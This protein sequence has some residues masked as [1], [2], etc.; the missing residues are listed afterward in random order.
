MR[1][2]VVG[3]SRF[4]MRNDGK[5]GTI[6]DLY[7]NPEKLNDYIHEGRQAVIDKY[8]WAVDGAKLTELYHS[9]S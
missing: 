5:A 1:N 4:H 2:G 9:I 6:E 7:K 8:N 3:M